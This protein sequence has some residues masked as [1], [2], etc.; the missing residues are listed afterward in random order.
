MNSQDQDESDE[1]Q[2]IN[3]R[4]MNKKKRASKANNNSSENEELD[5]VLN[6]PATWE[7]DDPIEPIIE[8]PL[9]VSQ[10]HSY[11]LK[12]GIKLSVNSDRN[13]IH[14][15]KTQSQKLT[16]VI[17]LRTLEVTSQENQVLEELNPSESR[18]PIDLIA[19]IDCSG[20][21]SGKK[22][23]TVKEALKILLPFFSEK[24][25]LS[26][27]KFESKAKKVMSLKRTSAVNMDVIHKIISSELRAV[28]STSIPSGMAEA[29][30]IIKNRVSKNKIVSVFLL[31]D[32]NDND[33]NAGEQVQKMLELNAQNSEFTIHCFGFGDDH[34][35]KLLNDIAKLRNGNFY[36]IHDLEN[37]NECFINAFGGLLS[38]VGREALL[39]VKLET[40]G[41]SLKE[42][43]DMKWLK[44]YG[45][46]W[47]LNVQTNEYE[48]NIQNLINGMKRDY[49]IDVQIPRVNSDIQENLREEVIL[50]C[51]LYAKSIENNEEVTKEEKL[52]AKFYQEDEEFKEANVELNEEVVVNLFRVQVGEVMEIAL[53]LAEAS[54][55]N[56]AIK[57]IENLINKILIS[58]DAK[59]PSLQKFIEQLEKAK[60]NCSPKVF[61]DTGR[62]E[63]INEGEV[64]MK[65]RG[66]KNKQKKVD[67][68]N[69]D[70]D[71]DENENTI[72]RTLKRKIKKPQPKPD[73][74]LGLSTVVENSTTM[75]AGSKLI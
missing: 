30:N 15:S 33:A 20:S 8:N 6:R 18:L 69:N 35:S 64:T 63:L 53:K 3:R 49:V 26:I 39:K 56:D 75:E 72:Q 34:D 27:V 29:V 71:S 16:T 48:I 73:K 50:S 61:E 41:H 43:S 4:K 28:G 44:A 45:D 11:D 25:R 23:E 46:F 1:E 51:V 42:L 14:C 36:Y 54:K 10:Q 24:D 47:K 68:K 21:M 37:I 62:H 19:V 17:S 59:N 40:V 12:K 2:T 66:L 65:Q 7:M 55:N 58:K 57:E 9:Q 13:I 32:G 74:S 67:V 52:K 70:S 5:S 22:I 60:R 38:I 31:S